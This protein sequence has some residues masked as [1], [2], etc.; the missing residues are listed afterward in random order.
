WRF[1][2]DG[3]HFARA[4][5]FAVGYGPGDETLAHTTREHIEISEVESALRG[6]AALAHDLAC[7][8]ERERAGY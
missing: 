2:T 7:E 6:N 4:G 8:F 1:A 3:G 5:L